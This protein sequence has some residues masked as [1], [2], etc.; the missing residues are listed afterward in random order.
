MPPITPRVRPPSAPSG[1]P[2]A[3]KARPR[4]EPGTEGLRGLAAILVLYTH[5]VA[6]STDVDPN[7]RI[8]AWFWK[9]D[10][11]QGAVLLFFVLS[12][13]VIGMT[14]AEPLHLASAR[15]YYHRRL[16][17]VVPLYLVAVLLGFASRPV[18]SGRTLAGNLLFLENELPYGSWRWPLLTGNTNLW[19]LNYEMLF[20]LAFPL[21]W[22][23]PRWWSAWLL[24]S[25]AAG[26]AAWSWGGGGA[27]LAAYFASWTFWLAGYG[28]ALA[29]KPEGAAAR[30]VPWPSIALAWLAARHLKPLWNVAHRF[31]FLPP[32]AGWMNY[33]FYDFIP[34]CLALL[35]AASGRRPAIGRWLIGFAI[36]EPAAYSVWLVLRGRAFGSGQE[37]DV[38]FAG[39]AAALCWWRPSARAFAGLAVVGSVSYG[40]YVFQRPVQ[41]FIRDFTWLPSGSL[42][43]YLLRLVLA[44]ALVAAL[45]WF[46]ER[47]FQPWLRR[48]LAPPLA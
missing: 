39:S 38:L 30:S 23:I 40:L 36:A 32:A 29:P 46:G 3:A 48:R 34:G 7:Y 19:S 11:S 44:L 26:V 42:A 21:V 20:Y 24:G 14:N 5:L 6:A 22:M 9:L 35:I 43:A 25:A 45:S 41:W 33:S 8:A 37:L 2:A 17:R 31:A 1:G 16:L 47:R 18:D 15:N 27:V 28:L 12:G 13:Y 4:R 10:V